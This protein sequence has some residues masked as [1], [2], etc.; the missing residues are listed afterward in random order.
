MNHF[1]HKGL[2]DRTI[3][4]VLVGAG[5]TGSRMLENLANLHRALTALGHPGGLHVC[6]ID[7]DVVSS[8]NIGRQAFYPC[9]IGSYKAATL[10]NRIN[11]SMGVQ[12]EAR[13]ERLT[14]K[15]SFGYG[16]VDLMIGAVDNRS[17]RLAMLRVLEARQGGPTYWLDLGNRSNDGQFLLG[18]V[19]HR[20][21][22]TD[23]K[24]RLPHIGELFPE[25]IDSAQDKESDEEP[26]CSLAEALEKQSLFI[27]PSVA[28]MASSLLWN[29][30]HKGQID[31]HGGFVNLS[32]GSVM[33]IPIDTEFWG[34]FGIER[35]GRRKKVVQPSKKA[36]A[37]NL[38]A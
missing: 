32:A 35:N 33:Q 38:P 5:G 16:K 30:L 17:A 21:R 36:L 22:K 12:W 27:N 26:S 19:N 34:R 31:F 25:L 28:C 11:M 18:E 24:A 23:D 29:L 3:H 4:V 1:L 14:T 13:I 2:S 15:T 37:A 8:S 20:D 10:V 6:V 7:S 9:D